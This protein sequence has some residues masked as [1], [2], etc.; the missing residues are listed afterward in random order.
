MSYDR[1]LVARGLANYR[2]YNTLSFFAPHLRYSSGSGADSSVRKFNRTVKALHSAGL[3]VILDVVYDHTA[4]GTQLGPTLSLRGVDNA[5]Y[6]RL[7][8]EDKRYYLDFTGCG[9]TLNMQSPQ[10][11]QLIMDSLDEVDERGRQVRGDTL[12]ILLNAHRDKVPFA[13][14][15]ITEGTVWVRTIDTIEPYVEECRY[16]G[17]QRDPAP[18]QDAR[19]IRPAQ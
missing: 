5:S 18:G 8:P 14:P 3:E 19:G 10:V 17:G 16:T 7:V 13:L 4:E 1:H 6:Y 2:G 9:N 15:T 11:L 12:L